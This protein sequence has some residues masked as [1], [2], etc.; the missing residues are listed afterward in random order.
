M[1]LTTLPVSRDR[2]RARLYS[3]S[4]S[5]PL[6][7][8][9]VYLVLVLPIYV[10][11]NAGSGLNMPQNLLAWIAMTLCILLTILRAVITGQLRASILMLWITFAVLL[12]MLPWLWTPTQLW[13]QHALPRLAGIAGAF[14][15]TLALSQIRMSYTLRRVIFCT[16]ALS[17]LLQAVEAM[18]QAWLPALAYRFM[19]FQAQS[20]Y[21]IFQQRNLLASWLATG[22]GVALYLLLTA[23][24]R[25]QTFIWIMAL[26]PLCIA[27]TL[28]ASRT[29]ALGALAMTLLAG[30]ADLPRMRKSKQAVLRRTILL[31]SLLITCMATAFWGM[32]EGGAEFKHALSNRERMVM[33]KGALSMAAEH[34]FTGS[35]LGSFEAIFP[36]VLERA[37]LQA[38]SDTITHPHNE[39]LYVLDEGGIVAL[40]GILILL[41][42]WFWPFINSL[43]CHYRHWLLPLAGL[44]LIT[45]M[46]TEYPLYLSAPHLLLL[47]LLFRA[48][49]SEEKISIVRSPHLL[50]MTILPAGCIA[51]CAALA[52]LNVGLSTQSNLTLAEAD[53]N[54][55]LIPILPPTDWRSITQAERLDYDRHMLAAN[56]PGF[57]RSPREMTIFK[58]WGE[59]WLAVHN[60]AEV[61]AAMMFIARHRGDLKEAERIRSRAER[62]FVHDGRFHAE[63]R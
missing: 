28:T 40:A 59:R 4:E 57:S 43:R 46:M 51:A 33:L 11:N 21:G 47:L 17:T 58:E 44:P 14:C 13:Q 15:F 12:L 53:M 34:P 61:S 9:L 52:V 10:N 56:Q 24:R 26:Y 63:V 29:G 45:H 3:L 16:V 8:V 30:L 5:W 31:S 49:I 55:G 2:G 41:C 1:T 62:V 37:G 50:R 54:A 20:P 60:D 32:S 48:G 35:G 22:Y 7:P 25:I 27:L 39:L 18:V 19:D 6:L 36:D 23:R 38:R 42:I